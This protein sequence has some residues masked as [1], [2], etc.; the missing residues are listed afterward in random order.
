CHRRR[1]AAGD[2]VALGVEDTRHA[3]GD[4]ARAFDPF[5]TTKEVGKGTSLRL[6]IVRGFATCI[7]GFFVF[8]G[9][10]MLLGTPNPHPESPSTPSPRRPIGRTSPHRSNGR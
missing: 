1:R 10:R 5:F 8:W 3:A 4:R 7:Q 6:S 9:Y 2:Y